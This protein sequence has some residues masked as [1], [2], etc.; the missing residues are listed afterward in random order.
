MRGYQGEAKNPFNIQ[1]QL[2]ISFE[3]FVYAI[4]VDNKIVIDFNR[5]YNPYCAYNPAYSC[6]V[7]PA[8]N[9]LPLEIRAGEKTFKRRGFSK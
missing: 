9:S 4:I 8:E 2:T 5:A 7:P 3:E 6:P 1:Q